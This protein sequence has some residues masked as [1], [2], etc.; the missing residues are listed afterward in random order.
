MFNLCYDHYA[1]DFEKLP[2]FYVY[3][4]FELKKN[5]WSAWYAVIVSVIKM[6]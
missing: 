5:M 6:G 3:S 1:N 2:W 4:G